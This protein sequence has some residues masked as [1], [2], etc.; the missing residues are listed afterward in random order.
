LTSALQDCIDKREPAQ[1]VADNYNDAVASGARATP[2]SV[3]I[4]E[5][6]KKFVLK[7]SLPYSSVK[8]VID[9]LLQDK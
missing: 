3:I 2:F 8:S 4:T 7:G 6:N 5:D 1:K 9:T